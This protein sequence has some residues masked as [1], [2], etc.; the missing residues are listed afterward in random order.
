DLDRAVHARTEAAGPAEAYGQL[1]LV[2]IQGHYLK[3]PVTRGRWRLSALQS[4]PAAPLAPDPAAENQHKRERKSIPRHGIFQVL[5]WK[6]DARD[7]SDRQPAR[8]GFG[9]RIDEERID[10]LDIEACRP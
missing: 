4:R 7:P 9:I 6:V 8:I 5:V 10:L 3:S 1:W 2:T